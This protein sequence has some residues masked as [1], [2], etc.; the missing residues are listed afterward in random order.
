MYNVV[1]IINKPSQ[2]VTTA[3]VEFNTHR[4]AEAFAN[5]LRED[6]Q[7]NTVFSLRYYI[8]PKGEVD[9]E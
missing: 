3:V 5:Q 1:L 6:L 4:A 9:F 8:C 7:D 2:A